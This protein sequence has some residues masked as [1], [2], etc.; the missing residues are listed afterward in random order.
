MKGA[1]IDVG[2]NST[3]LLIA[4]RSG[5]S[6][7][8]I[9]RE[10]RITRLGEGL[11][12]T[13]VIT[14]PAIERTSKVMKAY[15]DEALRLGARQMAAF[16]TAALREASNRSEALTELKNLTGLHI[17]VLTGEE[18]ALATFLGTAADFN[19]KPRTVIDIGGG[20]TEFIWGAERVESF[21]S[22][23]IGCV[24]ISERYGLEGLVSE[25]TVFSTTKE[26]ES[27]FKKTIVNCSCKDYQT[28]AVGGTATSLSA[29]NIKLE[30]YNRRR[31]HLSRFSI[32][33]LMAL[34]RNIA[35]MTLEE[36]KKIPVLDPARADVILAGSIILLAAL[37]SLGT[38]ELIVSE[39]DIL[40]GLFLSTF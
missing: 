18:E 8:E 5:Q 13:G 2:T 40:D 37:R 10:T 4:E 1:I 11:I 29:M 19:F 12:N 20:S 35:S 36:R 31:V 25:K 34:I 28:V 14:S 9:H 24:K 30:S 22:L 15:M 38:Q 3:R 21:L 7:S 23:P 6:I 16:G 33:E 32:D 26:I 39:R 17:S 27:H